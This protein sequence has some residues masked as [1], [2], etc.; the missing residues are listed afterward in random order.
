MESE[1]EGDEQD[2]E[3]NNEDGSN[4]NKQFE[5]LGYIM[6]R[7]RNKRI[8]ELREKKEAKPP[9][10]EEKKAALAENVEQR[11]EKEKQ[12]L[13]EMSQILQTKKKTDRKA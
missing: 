7:E 2:M 13:E 5:N 6:S 4:P 3:I 9:T 11:K 8:K 10:R 1:I 12:V